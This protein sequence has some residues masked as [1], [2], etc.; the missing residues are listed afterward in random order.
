MRFLRLGLIISLSGL[1]FLLNA[2]EG[3]P[4]DKK[5]GY[6]MNQQSSNTNL[7]HQFIETSQGKI[8]IWDT[9]PH[10]ESQTPT[11]IFIHGHCTNKDFFS[12]Q[13]TSPILANY[14]L[15]ALDLPGYG[16]S[17]PPNDPPKVY[18]FPGFADIV[19]EVITL[20]KLDNVIV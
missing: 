15:I 16:K 3:R 12:K 14:R 18:S 19:S 2:H 7:H 6:L 5:G 4:I 1:T 17:N 11:V 8:A 20:M 9:K 13:L 10:N